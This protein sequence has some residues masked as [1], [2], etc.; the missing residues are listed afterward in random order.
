M[1]EP[2]EPDWTQPLEQLRLADLKPHP[3]NDG[4]HPPEEIAHLKQSLTEHGVYR[5][6]VV[7]QDGTILAGHG[8]VEAARAVGWT[9]LPGQRRPYG[10]EDPRALKI[11]VGDN[12]IARLREQNDATL[13]ALLKDLAA[14]DG[15]GLLGTGFD[16]VALE[17]LLAKGIVPD[18]QPAGMDEQGR[19]DQKEPIICPECGAE[20]TR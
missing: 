4:Y 14:D 5:N 13:A 8:V 19:L 18:F 6:V 3:R 12:H 11:L 16:T 17:T 20:F 2:R 9:H 1:A 15:L 10:P 7:A